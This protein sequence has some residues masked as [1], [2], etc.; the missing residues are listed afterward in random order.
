MTMKRTLFIVPV[1]V[2]CALIG[3]LGY[4]ALSADYAYRQTVLQLQA[5]SR[6]LITV[7]AMHYGVV[8]STDTTQHTIGIKTSDPYDPTAEPL[9]FV[10]TVTPLTVI[11]HQELQGEG[12]YSSRSSPTPATLADIPVGSRVKFFSNQQNGLRTARIIFFGN[13][14]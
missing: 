12:G 11:A 2:V 14:L 1:I 6:A 5:M 7:G 8:V 3:F 10:L 4:A 13:P 9:L